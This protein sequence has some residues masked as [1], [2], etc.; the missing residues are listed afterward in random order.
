MKPSAPCSLQTRLLLMALGV[1]SA[2]WL[3]AAGITWLD[4]SHELDELLDG[5]LAQAA[6]LLVAQQARPEDEGERHD[7]A[8][9]DAPSLHR[10]APK[11]A[12]QV[13]H[14]G[15]LVV[16]SSNAS[17]Y[18]MSAQAHGFST[19]QLADGNAWRVFGTQGSENDIQ[20]YVGEHMASRHRILRSILHGMLLPLVFSLPIAALLLWWAVRKGLHPLRQLS[21]ILGQRQP[22][23]LEPVELKHA[24]S[25][26]QPL[27][28]ALNALFARIDAMVSAER[29]FT[30][31]AAHELR[32]PI[33]AIRAQAQVALG[34]AGDVAQRDRALHL[35]LAGCDRAT[36]VVEQ[37]L[38]LARL[39]AANAADAQALHSTPTRV[40]IST[41]VRRVAADLAPS[42]LARS[43]SLELHASDACH[44]TGNETLL[45][46]MVRNIL[47]NALRYSPPKARIEVQVQA[48]SDHT[49]L[50]VQDSGEGMHVQDIARL[51]ERFYRVL[52]KQQPGSG[53]GWSIIRRIAAVSGAQVHVEKSHRLGGLAVEVRWP[54]LGAAHSGVHLPA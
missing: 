33:A 27:V 38:T 46:V 23:A 21:H 36:R 7:D 14:A 17:K 12:F 34:A 31:D 3:V 47:D 19:V 4:A 37:L 9:S 52:G 26:I 18:P 28:Q 43:Q 44:V 24:P 8:I 40:D 41:L 5:H 15:Q 29:R 11:V 30:A 51:G 48:V 50:Q 25:D 2:V 16:R 32:T 6:A 39:E 54:L 42:A 1:L 35:T 22:Q 13:F 45:E 49:V 10:Y 20:V 53:L